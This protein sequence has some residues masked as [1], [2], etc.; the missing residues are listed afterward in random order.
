MIADRSTDVNVFRKGDPMSV[1]P[2]ACCT[3]FLETPL[4]EDQAQGLAHA[5]AALADPVRIRLLSLV[6]AAG[7][8]C[9]CELL[10]PL[11]KSQP[12]VS[13]HT[14]ILSEAGLITGEKRGRWVWWSLVPER[15]QDLRDALSLSAPARV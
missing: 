11:G 14:K 4:D 15:V 8:V 1:E 3:P 5:F 10:A 7:E 6:A 9:A 13:H 12:T 2:A